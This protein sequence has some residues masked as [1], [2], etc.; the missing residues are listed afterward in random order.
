MNCN[1][2]KLTCIN[3]L[4]IIYIAIFIK[5]IILRHFWRI[6]AKTNNLHH[7]W[8]FSISFFHTVFYVFSAHSYASR[9]IYSVFL[10][11]GHIWYFG[12]IRFNWN[13]VYWDYFR[14]LKYTL[15]ENCTYLYL[16]FAHISNMAR[17]FLNYEKFIGI[18][19]VEFRYKIKT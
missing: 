5:K 16:T 2:Y 18:F 11:K 4:S 1:E 3:E 7:H 6:L 15:W 8:F 12:W 14:V 13:G 10:L 19:E 17:S 9:N